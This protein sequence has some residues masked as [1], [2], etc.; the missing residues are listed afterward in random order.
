MEEAR[1]TYAPFTTTREGKGR[2]SF[3]S[4]LIPVIPNIHAFLLP[5]RPPADEFKGGEKTGASLECT[6]AYIFRIRK[7]IIR[8]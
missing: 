8:L 3:A 6:H 1:V 4:D 7:K 5:P 2:N